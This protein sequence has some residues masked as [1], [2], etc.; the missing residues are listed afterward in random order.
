M[1]PYASGSSYVLMES[2]NAAAACVR[3]GFLV[4]E[5]VARQEDMVQYMR[6]AAYSDR[7]STLR[8]R[9]QEPGEEA[10]TVVSGDNRFTI[11]EPNGDLHDGAAYGGYRVTQPLGVVADAVV[12]V[13]VS[14]RLSVQLTNGWKLAAGSAQAM[15][16]QEFAAALTGRDLTGETEESLS[17]YFYQERMQNQ[18]AAYVDRGE[19]V[20]STQA[21]Y[22][23]AQN[24]Q[25]AA[26][27]VTLH[28]TG[29]ATEDVYITDLERNVPQ[30]IRMFIWLE[31]QDE[32][33][34]SL[35]GTYGFTMSVELAGSN[36]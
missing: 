18:L 32:D 16:Q 24:G 1:Q 6:S 11:Y 13:D 28:T 14:D 5:D 29:G 21:L 17:R 20:R 15:L 19:F 30:R 27:D 34:R 4:N 10:S 2:E 7:F 12:P 35:S 8:G 36:G 22:A 3:V 33:C 26:S 25:V 9:Y 23:A 31:G